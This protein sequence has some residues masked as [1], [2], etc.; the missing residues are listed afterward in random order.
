[1]KGFSVQKKFRFHKRT[2]LEP[3]KEKEKYSDIVAEIIRISDVV[4]EVLDAR[5]IS[6]T[7]N[8]EVEKLIKDLGKEIIF[9][10][11]KSD[12]VDLK[13]LRESLPEEIH[14]R[15]FI[16][17]KSGRGGNILR[18]RIKIEAKRAN[19]HA[20]YNRKHIGIIGY[21]NT[22]KS[23]LINFLIGRKVAKTSIEA[24]FTKGMQKI[25][26]AEN[27]LLIDTPGVIPEKEYAYER[28][29]KTGK[30]AR[31]GARS[32]GQVKDP[33]AEVY[34]LL[35]N[36]SEIIQRYYGFKDLDFDDFIEQ[37][38]RKNNFLL[39]GNTVDEERTFR[40]IL[41]DWQLGNIRII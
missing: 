10:I 1:M 2:S 9:V 26:L 7:R 21:P 4:L 5:F 12:L 17:C 19:T 24:G 25:K 28:I 32:Y 31:I 13:K 8:L 18:D 30:H 16:S 41:K 11:N 35:D 36:Y 3:V 39:K 23:S 38:G 6:E 15:V 29:M 14:P 22:G 34:S 33:R 20:N 37:L 27:I 40:M